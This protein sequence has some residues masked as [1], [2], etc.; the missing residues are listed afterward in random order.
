MKATRLLLVGMI[1]FVVANCADQ[2][3]LGVTAAP[4]NSSSAVRATSG[5]QKDLL[6]DVTGLVG[7]LAQNLGLLK[8]TPLPKA[9]ST[10]TIGPWGGSLTVGPHTFVVPAGAL[11]QNVTITASLS[12]DTVNAITFQPAG[13]QFAKPASL[14]MSYANCNL[15]GRLLPKHIAYTD[16]N[17]VILQ[18]LV[19]ID[20]LFTRK[21]TGQV[22]HFS[23]YALAW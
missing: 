13:L 7:S 23:H 18:L 10:A 4:T 19:S 9:T 20:N 2:G 8:C 5:P 6:G 21:V 11:S 15:L 14:T 1:A 22:H 17:Y 3:P 16:D 12:A